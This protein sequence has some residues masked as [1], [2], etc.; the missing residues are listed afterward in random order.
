MAER[1]DTALYFNELAAVRGGFV[2]LSGHL[3]ILEDE[4]AEHTRMA[5][6]NQSG[7]GHLGDI[8]GIVWSVCAYEE[9]D[10]AR[11]VIAACK[12]GLVR[13]YQGTATQDEQIDIGSGSIF[14]VRR[15]GSTVFAC[16]SLHQVYRRTDSAWDHFDSGIAEQPEQER[17]PA[18]FGIDGAHEDCIYCVGRRGVIAHYDGQ[19]WAMME[20]PTNASLERVLCLSEDEVYICGR[21]GLF[22][23]GAGNQWESLGD[24]GYTEHFWGLTKFQDKIYVCSD[25]DLFEFD[26]NALVK[27]DTGLDGE[28]SY[29]RL[30]ATGDELWATSGREDVYRF[31][32][33]TW[34]RLICPD[35]RP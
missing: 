6:V 4:D 19:R 5:R 29:Y 11:T 21:N 20:S 2:Y 3:Y 24:P 15:I 18:F 7:W 31:D 14:Q 35:N 26:G 12:D 33:S 8:D 9:S 32:G 1:P 27:V 22:F 17:R 10:G 16:G 34:E 30:D 25:A 28:L 23:R 13:C